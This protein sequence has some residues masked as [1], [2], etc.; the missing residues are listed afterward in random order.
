MVIFFIENKV[1]GLVFFNHKNKLLANEKV[2][3]LVVAALK[4]SGC[5]IGWIL[6]GRAIKNGRVNCSVKKDFVTAMQTIW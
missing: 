4:V 1:V 6:N 2:V 3:S 5:F